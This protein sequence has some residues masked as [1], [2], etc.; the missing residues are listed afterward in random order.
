M[1]STTSTRPWLSAVEWSLSMASVA[2]VTPDRDQR[3]EAAGPKRGH[4]VAGAVRLPLDPLLVPS[5]VAE[6]VAP[7]GGAQ[8]RA[9]QVGD[10]AHLRGAQG[11]DT[12]EAEQ[13]LVPAQDAVRVPAA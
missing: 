8:D 4:Q 12:V 13:A 1:T 11:H 6:G 2:A 10:P 7:V 9:A 5:H 3:V